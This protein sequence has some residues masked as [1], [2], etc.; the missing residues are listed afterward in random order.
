MMAPPDVK[1][2]RLT[3]KLDVTK[4]RFTASK[5]PSNLD[6]IVIGS[7]MNLLLSQVFLLPTPYSQNKLLS[8]EGDYIFRIMRGFLLA[9]HLAR[10][11]V[12]PHPSGTTFLC[13]LQ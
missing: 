4:N 8:I 11:L 1:K 7:G 9:V 2:E 10:L 3:E 6:A 5:V 13:H 12:W